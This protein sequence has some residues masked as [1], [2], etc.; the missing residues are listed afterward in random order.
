MKSK[1]IE[2]CPCS[3]EITI[4]RDGTS[5]CPECGHH[6]VLPCSVCEYRNTGCDWHQT[7]GCRAFPIKG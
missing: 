7:K 4:K 5:T 2:M 6:P 1:I 3:A